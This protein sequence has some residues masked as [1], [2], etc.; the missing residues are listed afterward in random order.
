MKKEKAFLR[1]LIAGFCALPLIFGAVSCSSD[2][3]DDDT[4]TVIDQNDSGSKT[5]STTVTNS[6]GSTTTTTTN[7]DGSKVEVTTATDGSTT[8]TT[9]ATDGSKVVVT[10]DK[11]GNTT[12][13]KYDS[14]GNVITS[15]DSEETDDD[16]FYPA[17]GSTDAFVDTDLYVVYDSD[18]EIDRE[19]MERK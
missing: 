10:T 7:A 9:T 8:T 17:N 16:E 2:T 18:I 6:D 13:V 5:D 3:D 19:A 12:T 4:K 15:E 1:A 11:D 14:E